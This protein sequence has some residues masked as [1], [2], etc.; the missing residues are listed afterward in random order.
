KNSFIGT[1]KRS[2]DRKNGKISDLQ[3]R[4]SG[5]ESQLKSE[6]SSLEDLI[7]TK[8]DRLSLLE[9][10]AKKLASENEQLRSRIV[11][12]YT[13]LDNHTSQMFSEL[14]S[15]R[16]QL[17]AD[18]NQKDSSIEMLKRSI[19]RKE[20]EHLE[21]Q[22]RVNA[23]EQRLKDEQLSLE[24]EL[25]IKKDELASLEEKA[26]KLETLEEVIKTK[27]NEIDLLEEKAKEFESKKLMLARIK[28]FEDES[29]R[30]YYCMDLNPENP[31]VALQDHF[32][33]LDEKA[34]KCIARNYGW[35]ANMI[36]KLCLALERLPKESLRQISQEGDMMNF[37]L[38]SASRVFVAQKMIS[39]TE[40]EE[41]AR[42]MLELILN[43]PEVETVCWAWKIAVDKAKA[44]ET[45]KNL[46]TRETAVYSY[47]ES[48]N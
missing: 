43:L 31:S 13:D 7:K 1:L 9:E 18:L 37:D 26:K 48:S 25:K 4:T 20:K 23:L 36:R 27:D 14:E 6:R 32:K 15:E 10:K 38:A 42:E 22:Q 41:S 16:D 39:T 17:L 28:I 34:V 19:S 29:G 3:K 30:S 2:L 11:S 33:L 46:Y 44:I 21:L 35:R 24:N 5:L 8:D 45:F 12:V 40:N 47:I